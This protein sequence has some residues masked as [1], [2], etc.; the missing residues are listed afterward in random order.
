MKAGLVEVKREA[1]V[2]DRWTL[3]TARAPETRTP[4]ASR[5]ELASML[6]LESAGAN[7][8]AAEPLWVDTGA[9]Q[10]VIPLASADLVRRCAPTAP[11]LLAHGFSEKRGAAMAYAW[12]PIAEGEVLARFFFLVNGGVVEDPATGSACANL[13]GWHLATK[14]QLPVHLR[15]RQ[16]E[17]IHRPSVLDLHVDPEGRVFVGGAVREVAR[18]EFA[19]I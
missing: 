16:G 18:G 12:A 11:L 5:A 4:K 19:A 13:G 15:V 14:K 1:G 9:E 7:A 6:G 2:L 8:I 3:R 17:A 10:L